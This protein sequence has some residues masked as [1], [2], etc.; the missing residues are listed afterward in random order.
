MAFLKPQQTF[1]GQHAPHRVLEVAYLALVI[2]P[3][4]DFHWYRKGEDG[5]WTH[6]PG[7]TPATNVDNSGHL[8]SSTVT[9]KSHSSRD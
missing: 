5:M 1:I 9:S 6:K 3:G 7:G 2:A 4:W 8:T